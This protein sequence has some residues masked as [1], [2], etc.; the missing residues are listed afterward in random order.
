MFGGVAC[1]V[2]FPVHRGNVGTKHWTHLR[3]TAQRMDWM[4]SRSSGEASTTAFHIA[5]RRDG[6]RRDLPA[7]SVWQLCNAVQ[8]LPMRRQLQVWRQLWLAARPARAPASRPRDRVRFR[9]PESQ[10]QQF[11]TF[12][13][14]PARPHAAARPSAA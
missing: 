8:A 1:V 7:S 3:L 11:Y 6:C 9:A 14:E 4:T 12:Q 5:I 10:F 2:Q 13:A